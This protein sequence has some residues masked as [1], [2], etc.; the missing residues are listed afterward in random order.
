M[1]YFPNPHQAIKNLVLQK[2]TKK[3]KW[4]LSALIM[5]GFGLMVTFLVWYLKFNTPGHPLLFYSFTFAVFFLVSRI[6]FEW[7][8]FLGIDIPEK[9]ELTR[10]W[11]VDILTT[12]CAGEPYKM[13]E[14]T[15]LAMKNIRYPHKTIYLCD[16]AND[17]FLQAFCQEHGIV[18]VTRTDKTGAKAGNINNA[19]KQATGDI[20][21]IMDPD[22]VP[23]PEFLDQ[24]LPYFEDEKVGYVQCCQGYYNQ[25]ESPI[26]RGACEQTY[27]FYGPQMMGMGTYGTA[28][29]IGANCTFRRSALDSINGHSF[30]LA[31]DMHTS[32][33][34]QAKGWKSVYIPEMLSRGLVPADIVAY[35]KQ[36]LKWARG[37][38][39]LLFERY[40]LLFKNFNWRQRFHH[41]MTPFFYLNG[42]VSFIFF[43][44]PILALF[45]SD[46]PVHV[47]FF[48][49]ITYFAPVITL[50]L[51]IRQY[52]QRW[53]YKPQERGFHLTG[54]ILQVGTWYIYTLGFFYSIIR[55][56][57]PYI[58]TPKEGQEKNFFKLLTPHFIL[59]IGSVVAIFYG[60]A[61]DWNPYTWVMAGFAAANTL[62]LT[63]FILMC[64]QAWL[65]QIERFFSSKRFL[66]WAEATFGI[67]SFRYSQILYSFIRKGAVVLAI[68][69]FTLSFINNMGH[70]NV[71][72]P[73]PEE[74]SEKP[75]N[76]GGF[77]IGWEDTSADRPIVGAFP[78]SLESFS[79]EIKSPADT[80]QNPYGRFFKQLK[81]SQQPL[82][83]LQFDKEKGLDSNHVLQAINTGEMDESFIAF[84]DA[85]KK[86]AQPVLLSFMNNLP[87]KLTNQYEENDFKTAWKRLVFLLKQRGV[88]NAAPVFYAHS[89]RE[90]NIFF[91]GEDYVEWIVADASKDIGPED[92]DLSLKQWRKP[93]LY[94]LDVHAA[95]LTSN[96]NHIASLSYAG[97]L[98]FTYKA[99][100]SIP[101]TLTSTLSQNPYQKY[102][103][104]DTWTKNTE[105]AANLSAAAPSPMVVGSPEG[106]SLLKDG[107]P[108]FVKGIAYN[109]AHDWRDPNLPLTRKA[110]ETDFTHIK[111]LGANTIRRYGNS[112][113]DLNIM[114]VA[115][116]F[117]L[118]VMHGFWLE[119]ETD[120]LKDSTK[121]LKYEQEILA[122][123][124]QFKHHPSVLC[125]TIGNETWGL[126]KYHFGE[127]YLY[128]VRLAYV[129]FLEH[130]AKE[131]KA[132]DPLH[133][134]MTV[135]EHNESQVI[136]ELHMLKEYT[137]SLDIIGM[138]AYYE[139]QISQLDEVMDTHYPDKPYLVTEFGPRGYWHPTYTRFEKNH[140]V[141]EDSDKE[142]SRLYIDQWNKYIL[143][144]K[145]K[146]LGG[147]AYSWTDRMEGTAT[148]YGITDF[149]NRIKP[150][151]YALQ[152]VWTTDKKSPFSVT[153][154]YI[155]TDEE[156]FFPNRSYEFHAEVSGAEKKTFRYEWYLKKF[157][158][159]EDIHEGMHVFND[160]KSVRIKIPEEQSEYRLYLYVIDGENRVLTASKGL[161]TDYAFM[162]RMIP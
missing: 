125:W 90:L 108:F 56:K 32:M 156:I 88:S 148:W 35:Y 19:L 96:L 146:L 30:G 104:V 143:Q 28:Q 14:T 134:V 142:K 86:H 1:S 141:A 136:Q 75:L 37:S 160:G 64:Q 6:F 158:Y 74:K 120:Y 65:S 114:N 127:P 152:S 126:L 20:C 24:V 138:N 110:L 50:Q 67:F 137:A 94:K 107:K 45:M 66:H 123:V 23:V 139:E 9:P 68:L 135:I 73:V 95:D 33:N 129:R 145:G 111:S 55:K 113:Y 115:S 93:V 51:I 29:A 85:L 34:L 144:N 105:L 84:A 83:E 10:Q 62:I 77:Y 80:S 87:Q 46:V 36:Q 58:P 2:P 60:L 12:F 63:Y 149:K 82:I 116:E 130:L 76:Y 81:P 118:S 8:N 124:Q 154:A 71:E 61:R 159:L 21:L 79:L 97:G 102:P 89:P 22:H 18:H 11:K 121:L 119:A 47:D 131:I 54:G 112:P 117:Q 99:E 109:V 42:L 57:I 17:T 25:D 78:Q 44:L 13:I 150:A 132:I 41:I 151:F 92:Y 5:V 39:E 155:Q 4:V 48:E 140:L 3:E 49:F 103:K 69:T 72:M 15:L 16:E 38:F 31:E 27:H 162:Q 101:K 106:Y 153:E 43:A 7:Y 91:P 53:L 157:E 161:K 100:Q 26:A 147:V 70:K 122:Q 59:A 52:V 128:Q 40:P 133:P 98:I